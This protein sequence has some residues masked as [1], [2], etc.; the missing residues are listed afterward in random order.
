MPVTSVTYITAP[1]Q[2]AFTTATSVGLP[3]YLE[4]I[5][6]GVTEFTGVRQKMW[7]VATYYTP[8][9]LNTVATYF[10]TTCYL[11]EDRGFS[12]VGGGVMEFTREYRRLPSARTEDNGTIVSPIPWV[13]VFTSGGSNNR[14]FRAVP[15]L[16]YIEYFLTGAGTSYLTAAS[17]S[18]YNPNTTVVISA[19][20]GQ[21]T[22]SAITGPGGVGAFSYLAAPSTIE[23]YAGSIYMRKRTYTS[24]A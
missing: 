14:L 15:S 3:L 21:I 5:A 22:T 9:T 23:L 13:E 18:V 19:T 8:P 6:S 2:P 10:S 16:N 12:E 20:S 11:T 7:Q 17:I 24:G 1:G 4:P